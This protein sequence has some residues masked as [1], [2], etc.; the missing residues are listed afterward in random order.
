MKIVRDEL[1]KADIKTKGGKLQQK[2]SVNR[3]FRKTN[4]PFTRGSLRWSVLFPW[5]S[6]I[7]TR[8]DWTRTGHMI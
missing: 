4:G 6:A 2:W 3:K 7:Q 1:L 8:A 5:K